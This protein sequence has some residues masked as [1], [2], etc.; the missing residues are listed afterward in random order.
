MILQATE[1]RDEA[2]S[3]TKKLYLTIGDVAQLLQVGRSTAYLMVEK[4]ELPSV[5]IGKKLIRVP[6]NAL[7]EYFAAQLRGDDS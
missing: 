2:L 3:P 4:G 6:R 5:R 1:T 7:D